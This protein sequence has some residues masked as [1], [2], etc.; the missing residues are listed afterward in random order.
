MA[1][2]GAGCAA[3][4]LHAQLGHC[5]GHACP[6]SG[7]L[8]V[9]ACSLAAVTHPSVLPPA[10][11]C[12]PQV[13]LLYELGLRPSDFDRL[14][15]SRPEIFQM[16]I[17]TM[18]R[19]LKFLQDTIGLRWGALNGEWHV[20]GCMHINTLA[21][22]LVLRLTGLWESGYRLP[23]VISGSR[24]QRRPCCCCC[25]HATHAT[26]NRLCPCSNAQLAKV[27]SK[28]PRI[29]EYRSERTLRP[30]LDFLARCGVSQDDLAKVR[31]GWEEWR[32]GAPVVRVVPLR[33]VTLEPW[34][35]PS[36]CLDCLV[37]MTATVLVDDCHGTHASF[38]RFK[39]RLSTTSS[40]TV[41]RHPTP[42]PMHRCLSRRP[43]C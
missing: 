5:V 18:R 31:G 22:H 30:R 41:A 25:A 19:K 23:L 39:A 15:E 37:A 2:A 14:A 7:L 11:S 10:P 4:V 40:P 1:A 38:V 26:P 28:F 27:I 35:R 34:S 3:R 21:L 43:W 42:P 17:V 13:L 6:S 24:R 33:A 8:G 32:W 12:C 20:V 29:L 36:E 16:G 9:H